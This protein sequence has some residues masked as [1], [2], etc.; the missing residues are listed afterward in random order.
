LALANGD[1]AQVDTRRIEETLFELFDAHKVELSGEELHWKT[2]FLRE[3]ERD[4]RE[5]QLA[6][7][8]K[9]KPYFEQF[10]YVSEQLQRELQVDPTLLSDP[11]LITRRIR[12]AIPQQTN[13]LVLMAGE[14]QESFLEQLATVLEQT[15]PSIV[16][17]EEAQNA[18]RAIF[19]AAAEREL[20]PLTQKVAQEELL[21]EYREQPC[22]ARQDLL[23]QGAAL[24]KEFPELESFFIAETDRFKEVIRKD[25]VNE[26]LPIIEITEGLARATT[27][28]WENQAEVLQL[29]LR[30]DGETAPIVAEMFQQQ[31]GR[32]FGVSMT[33]VFGDPGMAYQIL[34]G[35]VTRDEQVLAAMQARIVGIGLEH[36]GTLRQYGVHPTTGSREWSP[37]VRE[38]GFQVVDD[39]VALLSRE[40][41][42]VLRAY[43]RIF[44]DAGAAPLAFLHDRKTRIAAAELHGLRTNDEA[45]KYAIELYQIHREDLGDSQREILLEY[46]RRFEQVPPELRARTLELMDKE[47]RTNVIQSLLQVPRMQEEGVSAYFQ[48]VIDNDRIAKHAA[49]IRLSENDYYHSFVDVLAVYQQARAEGTASQ[50]GERY[51]ALFGRELRLDQLQL[52]QF[53]IG[54][55]ED[56]DNIP[57]EVTRARNALYQNVMR[58][59]EL[60]QSALRTVLAHEAKTLA[61]EAA[62]DAAGSGSWRDIYARERKELEEAARTLDNG[63]GITTLLIDVA[64]SEAFFAERHEHI[65][66]NV[67][68]MARNNRMSQGVDGISAAQ[69][70]RNLEEVEQYLKV[71]M[72]IQEG[73]LYDSLIAHYQSS[74]EHYNELWARM[75]EK[76]RDLYNSFGDSFWNYNKFCRVITNGAAWNESKFEELTGNRWQ[77][78]SWGLNKT[79][80]KALEA[81]FRDVTNGTSLESRLRSQFYE[82]WENRSLYAV[83]Y[84]YAPEDPQHEKPLDLS[85]HF[86]RAD[87]DTLLSNIESANQIT[88]D[89]IALRQAL[90]SQDPLPAILE[91]LQKENARE[92]L[93]E[94]EKLYGRSFADELRTDLITSDE[95]VLPGDPRSGAERRVF[96]EATILK[97]LAARIQN[98]KEGEESPFSPQIIESIHYYSIQRLTRY[99]ATEARLQAGTVREHGMTSAATIEYDP[100]ALKKAVARRAE[101]ETFLDSFFAKEVREKETAQFR[102]AH[103]Q[104]MMRALMFNA[105]QLE[106]LAALGEHLQDSQLRTAH[107]LAS[108]T[109]P[110]VE[111]LALLAPENQSRL[112]DWRNSNR[113]GIAA[114]ARTDFRAAQQGVYDL[115]AAMKEGWNAWFGTDES[116][117]CTTL[118]NLTDEQRFLAIDLYAMRYHVSLRHHLRGEVEGDDA[119]RAFAEMRGDHLYADQLAILQSVQQWF[120]EDAG[121]QSAS[122]R[123]TQQL[124]EEARRLLAEEAATSEKRADQEEAAGNAEE[125]RRLRMSAHN[126]REASQAEVHRSV[127]LQSRIEELQGK[128]WTSFDSNLGDGELTRETLLTQELDT[129]DATEAIFLEGSSPDQAWRLQFQ[130]AIQD[131]PVEAARLIRRERD[132]FL[133]E[134]LN[135]EVTFSDDGKLN[136]TLNEKGE[137]VVD[138]EVISGDLLR[139]FYVSQLENQSLALEQRRRVLLE[140]N[141][142]PAQVAELSTAISNISEMIEGF[143]GENSSFTSFAKTVFGVDVEASGEGEAARHILELLT[144]NPESGAVNAQMIEQFERF[145]ERGVLAQRCRLAIAEG[146][147]FTD[148][149]HS[150]VAAAWKER[151]AEL[152]AVMAGAHGE[153]VTV[154]SYLRTNL[155]GQQRDWLLAELEGNLIVAAAHQ[156]RR[157]IQGDGDD[158]LAVEALLPIGLVRLGDE[159]ET[160]LRSLEESLPEDLVSAL[161][162]RRDATSQRIVLESLLRNAKG[163]QV[164]RIESQIAEQKVKEEAA[165]QIPEGYEALT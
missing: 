57:A 134:V 68:R 163:E 56:R 155:R 95:V 129:P 154:E 3:Q 148:E 132:R 86:T 131:D 41:G 59:E 101:F 85:A 62:E 103:E 38:Q 58:Q 98:P 96:N 30:L 121:V 162:A 87:T 63:Q 4:S 40:N 21:A 20:T 153:G 152:D 80:I 22:S 44:G 124:E 48:A 1:L 142:D 77:Q 24:T 17:T 82:N 78:R 35:V 25:V 143:Q 14:G 26:V 71:S 108:S 28:G 18:A 16:T 69:Q 130:Q 150:T 110:P 61:G 10:R 39:Y 9:K 141:G 116:K 92:I 99:A 90:Q 105:Q 159:L 147:I 97:E 156:V 144:I 45:M 137:L 15:V 83:S 37:E 120:G 145:V 94:H 2:E 117:I 7:T 89:A 118:R 50:V 72:G 102:L 52:T 138:G 19:L 109:Y 49:T 13:W 93:A 158:K 146:S 43:E 42:D 136:G 104:E 47:L 29:L 133:E 112:I 91:I 65:S 5:E 157:D 139:Q 123:I 161:H 33:Q 54:S 55:T 60:N 27:Y 12:G 164:A 160:E 151:V 81:C 88:M 113:P 73:A 140:H 149:R 165:I 66:R 126:L 135:L 23:T 32:D 51:K 6:E 127:A 128:F 111:A 8:I 64:Y 106:R 11:N 67:W 31:T 70:Q 115:H 100:E 46:A 79:E 84:R 74:A 53:N 119:A 76:A 75:H 34:T 122:R 114:Q 107:R 125:A 36:L